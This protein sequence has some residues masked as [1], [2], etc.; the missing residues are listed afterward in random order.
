MNKKFMK[1]AIEL[2][3]KAFD[4][5]EVPVGAVIVKN[6]TAGGL[7]IAKCMSPLSLAPCVRAQL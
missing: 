7:T 5:G 4:S 6:L 2:G 1:R 3:K